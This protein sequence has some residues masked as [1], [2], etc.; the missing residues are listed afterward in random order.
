M[1]IVK[2]VGVFQFD[3]TVIRNK[4]IG[5]WSRLLGPKL[6]AISFGILGLPDADSHRA[7]TIYKVQRA[8]C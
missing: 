3:S 1:V 2:V 7:V 5:K 8:L 6:L 4:S